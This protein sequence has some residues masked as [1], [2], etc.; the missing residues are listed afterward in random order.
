MVA[1]KKEKT[2]INAKGQFLLTRLEKLHKEIYDL[3][4]DINI[5]FKGFCDKGAKL[6]IESAYL[7]LD[8]AIIYQHNFVNKA[9]DGSL[10]ASETSKKKEEEKM[11]SRTY[12]LERLKKLESEQFVNQ[13]KEIGIRDL[14]PIIKEQT[15][16]IDIRKKAICIIQKQLKKEDYLSSCNQTKRLH[17][18]RYEMLAL[19]ETAISERSG[20]LDYEILRLIKISLEQE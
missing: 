8:N 7:N 12:L 11:L 10:Y 14:L 1:M 3:L 5:Q 9:R 19:C 2:N 4:T 17:L 15:V 6:S 16:P 13:E 20:D 18:D